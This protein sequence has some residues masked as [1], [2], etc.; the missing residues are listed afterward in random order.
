MQL[1]E[2]RWEDFSSTQCPNANLPSGIFTII[3][4][5]LI[6]AILVIQLGSDL[7]WGLALRRGVS[8]SHEYVFLG[9]DLLQL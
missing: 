3:G 1:A 9:Q 5:E 4:V 7:R 8:K 6:A 2:V